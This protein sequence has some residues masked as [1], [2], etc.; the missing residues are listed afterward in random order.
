MPQGLVIQ[1][2]KKGVASLWRWNLSERL[3][4]AESS[5]QELTYKEGTGKQ[6]KCDILPAH[7]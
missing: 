1:T 6:R 5:P 3:K 7:T 4:T 2:A